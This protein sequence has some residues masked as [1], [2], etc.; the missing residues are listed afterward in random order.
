MDIQSEIDQKQHTWQGALF[1]VH[2]SAVIHLITR[3]LKFRIKVVRNIREINYTKYF[4][5]Y[6]KNGLIICK[7]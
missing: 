2:H 6:T 5:K 1:S 4:L 7:S 3:R